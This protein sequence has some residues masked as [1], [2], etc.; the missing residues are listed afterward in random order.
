MSMSMSMSQASGGKRDARGS[1]TSGRQG[2]TF[3]RVE[4]RSI[5]RELDLLEEKEAEFAFTEEE[6]RG[7]AG[8]DSVDTKGTGLSAASGTSGMSGSSG[9]DRTGGTD[10]T[11]VD[12]KVAGDMRMG[13]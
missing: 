1:T 3:G 9:T 10:A 13:G 5:L 7:S 6:R 4:E 8:V 2:V 11:T 12:E